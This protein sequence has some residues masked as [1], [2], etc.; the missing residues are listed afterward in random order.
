MNYYLLDDITSIV[1]NSTELV[2]LKVSQSNS[3]DLNY[4]YCFVTHHIFYSNFM[5]KS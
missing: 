3:V 4:M 2:M 1:G 5:T